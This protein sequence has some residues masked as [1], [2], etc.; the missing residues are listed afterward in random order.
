MTAKGS[1]IGLYLAQSIAKIHKGRL[2]ASSN[3]PGQ[4]AAFHLVLPVPARKTQ[5]S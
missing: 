1:G 5:S 4:G 2:T 3:G